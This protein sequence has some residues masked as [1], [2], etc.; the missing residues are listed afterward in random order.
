LLALAGINWFDLGD[1]R[2]KK[3]LVLLL[4]CNKTSFYTNARIGGGKSS[5]K[6]HALVDLSAKS[7]TPPL[8]WTFNALAFAAQQRNA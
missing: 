3:A 1:F 6:A 7:R 5:C 8:D 4:Y 2:L